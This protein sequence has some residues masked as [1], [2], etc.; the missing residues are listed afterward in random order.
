MNIRYK[1]DIVKRTDFSCD[2]YFPDWD[3]FKAVSFDTEKEALDFISDQKC[4][5]Y[6]ITKI[7]SKE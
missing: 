5:E 3:G 2:V 4:Y 1:V 6:T 7:Y